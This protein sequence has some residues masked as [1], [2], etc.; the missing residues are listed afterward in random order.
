MYQYGETVVPQ[1][2]RVALP[3]DTTPEPLAFKSRLATAPV[4]V[5]TLL[6]FPIPTWQSSAPEADARLA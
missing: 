2:Q 4:V 3:H 5:R 6:R 1:R